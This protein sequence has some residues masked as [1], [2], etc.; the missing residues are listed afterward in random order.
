VQG[1]F[2]AKFFFLKLDRYILEPLSDH[3]VFLWHGYS[4]YLFLSVSLIMIKSLDEHFS[5][6]VLRNRVFKWWFTS[7]IAL[8]LE[9]LRISI[10]QDSVAK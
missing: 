3:H 2:V 1:H 9:F 6:T 8:T 7:L 4:E 5:A 10:S